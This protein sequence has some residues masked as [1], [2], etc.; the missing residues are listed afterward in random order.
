MNVRENVAVIAVFQIH[1]HC[2]GCAEKV[3]RAV[4]HLDGVSDVKVDL[5]SNRLTLTGKVDPVVIKTKLEKKTKKKIEIVSSQPIEDAGGHKKPDEKIEKKTDENM[6]NEIR[7]THIK[8]KDEEIHVSFGKLKSIEINFTG[9]NEI[10]IDA[11]KNLITTKRSIEGKDHVG[12]LNE[13]FKRSVEV[14][15]L[16][17][18]ETV[19]AG[20]DKKEKEAGGGSGGDKA[21]TSNGGGYEAST[22]SGGDGSGQKMEYS[23]FSYQPSTFYYEVPINFHEVQM[24]SDEN[25]NSCPIM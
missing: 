22:S 15:P 19:V 8:F 9:V 17:I 11:Q 18:G 6:T 12:Y 21:S 25:P 14:V 2:N 5:S 4:K 13:K 23:G 3:K 7:K 10:S 16:K 20:G 24:C 1:M